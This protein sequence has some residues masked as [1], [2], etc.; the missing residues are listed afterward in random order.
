MSL[1]T[2]ATIENATIHFANVRIS[3]MPLPPSRIR[4]EGRGPKPPPRALPHVL[5]PAVAVGPLVNRLRDVVDHESR[6]HRDGDFLYL[7]Q[8]DHLLSSLVGPIIGFT[9]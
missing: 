2:I 6:Y 8:V 3:S 7:F 5:W 4:W 9:L 1:V